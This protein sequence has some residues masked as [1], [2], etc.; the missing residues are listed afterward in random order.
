MKKPKIE[1]NRDTIIAIVGLV[2]F[3]VL[4]ILARMGGGEE[5]LQPEASPTPDIPIYSPEADEDDEKVT[6]DNYHF[7]YTIEK[8]ATKEV[9][10]GKVYASKAKFSILGASKEEYVKLS[11][12]YMRLVNGEYQV[13]DP[14]QIR[15]YLIYLDLDGI[16]TLQSFS[17]AK[18]EEDDIYEY[19]I[20]ITDLL[21]QY[22]DLD[23][24]AFADYKTDKM[25]I[26][27]NKKGYIKEIRL[28]YSNYFSYLSGKD[29]V[30]KVTME[31]D[32]YGEI[33]DFE[34]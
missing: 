6:S 19:E 1:M 23:Y 22:T 31:F 15:D 27:Y 24:D 7:T 13:I 10:D 18:N 3:L 20:E 21:D 34:V 25:T 32:Q 5:S 2:F 12:S 17:V 33:S 26:C 4:I 14:T 28:D 16:T 11:N 9:I 30:F 29:S 8:D